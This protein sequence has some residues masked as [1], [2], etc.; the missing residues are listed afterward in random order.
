MQ[1][2]EEVNVTNPRLRL[3][4]T[5]AKKLFKPASTNQGEEF[6]DDSN[7]HVQR[8]SEYEL[9]V[10]PRFSRQET[11]PYLKK[12]TYTNLFLINLI[13]KFGR[14]GGFDKILKRIENREQWIP[15]ELL[16]LYMQAL[17]HVVPLLHRDFCY[18]FIPK[19]Q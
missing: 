3:P 9:F 8:T 5:F 15:F 4:N 13:N 6:V 7:D 12:I 16:S 18:K 11:Q 14:V 17:S 10:V 1:Y 2:D 19:L